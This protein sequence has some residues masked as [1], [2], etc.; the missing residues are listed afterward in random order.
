MHISL[1]ILFGD[2]IH[3]MH[4]SSADGISELRRDEIMGFICKQTVVGLRTHDLE[5]TDMCILSVLMVGNDGDLN[6]VG[7]DGLPMPCMN[8]H[9]ALAKKT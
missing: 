4:V 3:M 8:K 1:T 5:K 6:E 7:C 2:P 9:W